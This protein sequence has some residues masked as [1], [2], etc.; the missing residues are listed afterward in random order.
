MDWIEQYMSLFVGRLSDHSVQLETGLYARTGKPLDRARVLAHLRGDV[1]L[2]TY[3]I[4]D[5]GRC[6]FAVFD[7]DRENDF[8]LLAGVQLRLRRSNIPAWL[9]RS[10]RGGHLWVFL[11][12]PVS[13]SDLR[14]WL[15]PFCP[16][17]IEFYPKQAKTA[18]VGSA[19]RLPFGIH[20]RSGRR[21]SFV[22]AREDGK[23]Q[24]V[25][26]RISDQVQFL[27]DQARAICPVIPTSAATPTQKKSFSNSAR[28]TT[29]APGQY[30]TIREWCA[31]Q[32]PFSLIGRYVDL[33]SGGRGRCPF[34]NH[35]LAGHDDHASFQVYTP[36]TPG[37]YCWYCRSWDQG[38]SVFDFLK[39]WHGIDARTLWQRIQRGEL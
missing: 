37:G 15:L 5:A 31:A 3:L 27:S 21:Y 2:A 25:G 32:D 4:D 13:P 8:V 17:G 6:R 29:S 34:G 12:G 23:W 33:D 36:G 39:L 7:G 22:E 38:G 14:A 19:I 24:A 28:L 16:A 1:S 10:R 9:E 18:G 26:A 35:H 11:A 20:R 30:P